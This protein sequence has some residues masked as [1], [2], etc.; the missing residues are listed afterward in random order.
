MKFSRVFRSVGRLLRRALMKP[1]DD[2]PHLPNPVDP[3]ELA[4][5]RGRRPDA[6]PGI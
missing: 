2:R 3:V 5:E 6:S 1:A 4:K